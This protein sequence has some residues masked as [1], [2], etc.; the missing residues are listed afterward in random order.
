MTNSKTGSSGDL[1]DD[2][3]L[4]CASS[5]SDFDLAGKIA[6]QS[7]GAPYNWEFKFNKM[8][9]SLPSKYKAEGLANLRFFC[10]DIIV[11]DY[12]NAL[13]ERSTI[14]GDNAV[15]GKAPIQYGQVPIANVPQMPT[16]YESST[17][18]A[19]TEGY[20]DGTATTSYKYAD[21]ILTHKNNFIIGMQRDL[22]MESKRAP[23]DEATYIFYSIRC[24]V[25]IENPEA[26]VFL[27]NITHS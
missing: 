9:S 20:N 2:A 21:C 25:A 10:N 17:G 16:T 3:T 11:S 7:T 23:E 12:V 8:I 5:T 22:K 27:Y 14:L 19:G 15:L 1:P 24:D 26:C 6:E 4:L 18:E 13:S